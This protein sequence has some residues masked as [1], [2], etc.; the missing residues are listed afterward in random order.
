M[1][2]NISYSENVIKRL[3]ALS[4]NICAFPNCDIAIVQTSGVL[5]GKI[6]H[7]K[8]RNPGG[9]RYDPNQT[10]KERS[11]F[12]N[13]ILLCSVHHDIVDSQPEEFTVERLQKMKAKHE[14]VGDIYLSQENDRFARLLIDSS[15]SIE[16]RRDSQVMVGSPG[17]IQAKNLTIKTDR[18]SMPAIQPPLDAVGASIDMKSYIEYLIRRYIDWRNR[19]IASGK[20]MRPF[21][22]SMIYRNV[23][24]TFGARAYLVSQN[25]FAD[26]VTYLQKRIDDTIEGK[27]KRSSGERNYHTFDEHL[28]KLHGK[29]NK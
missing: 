11:S 22:P 12:E 14:A 13:L 2:D 21:H 9:P 6:C 19:W 16:A 4:H 5:T 3:F 23:E 25:R 20:D 7:I 8:G 29:N 17:A 26:L 1:K 24:K 27:R 15:L 28:A 18:K 10:D